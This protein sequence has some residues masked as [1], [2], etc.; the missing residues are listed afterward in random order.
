MLTKEVKIFER[1]KFKRS[2][3]DVN[4]RGTAIFSMDKKLKAKYL[5]TEGTNKKIYF[6]I[7]ISSKAGNS[8]WRNKVKRLIRES[9]N[10][11]KNIFE[12][13]RKKIKSELVIIFSPYRLKQAKRNHLFLKDIRPAVVDIL[14]KIIETSAGEAKQIG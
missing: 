1:L 6:A 11:E 2:I 14:N 8:V 12:E 7:T 13:K 3:F 10:Q 4:K 9:I 5:T